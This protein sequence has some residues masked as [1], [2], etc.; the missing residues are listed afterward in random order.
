MGKRRAPVRKRKAHRGAE[1]PDPIRSL[2]PPGPTNL[3]SRLGIRYPPQYQTGWV[4]F[5][6]RCSEQRTP[7]VKPL[8]APLQRAEQ[9]EVA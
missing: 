1:R 7:M 9:V 8:R 2:L 6:R 3:Y 5:G 4:R